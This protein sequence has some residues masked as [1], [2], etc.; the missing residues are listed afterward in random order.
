MYLQ[1]VMPVFAVLCVVDRAAGALLLA[2]AAG[3]SAVWRDLRAAV[4]PSRGGETRQVRGAD[5]LLQHRHAG[6]GGGLGQK[7]PRLKQ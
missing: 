2:V 3:D 5:R 1:N 6:R 4:P 7:H